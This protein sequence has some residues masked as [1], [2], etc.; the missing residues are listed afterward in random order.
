MSLSH[1]KPAL[2]VLF[3]SMANIVS[4]QFCS[5]SNV[6]AEV[7]ECNDNGAFYVDLE[8][9]VSSPAADRFLI[10]GNG[11]IYDTF[12]YGQTFYTVGPLSADCRTLYEFVI[13]DLELDSCFGVFEFSEPVCCA[14]ECSFELVDIERSD[15]DST[16]YITISYD[17][18]NENGSDNG[19]LITV[20]GVVLESNAYGNGP[21]ELRI[22]GSPLVNTLIFQDADQPECND[23]YSLPF[24]EYCDLELDCP[25][26]IVSPFIEF[27]CVSDSSYE[28]YALI[29]YGGDEDSLWISFYEA[30]NTPPDY[31]SL[32]YVERVAVQNAP[33]YLGTFDVSNTLYYYFISEQNNPFCYTA[34]EWNDAPDCSN[35]GSCE[36]FDFQAESVECNNLNE[37]LLQFSFEIENQGNEGFVLVNNGIIVDSFSYD[38]GTSNLLSGIIPGGC[39]SFSNFYIQD[40]ELGCQSEE[41]LIDNACCNGD[42]EIDSITVYDFECNNDGS[43]NL[44]LDFEYINN[45]NELFDVYAGTIYIGTYRYDELPVRVSNFIPRDIEYDLIRVCDNDNPDCCRAHEFIGPDCFEQTSCR[46]SEVFAE[47]YEC[48]DNSFYVDIEFDIV[49]PGNEGFIIRGNGVVYDSFSYGERFYTVGPIELDCNRAYEFIIIDLKK[50]CRGVFEM[51]SV[52]CCSE[53]C[54]I[55]DIEVFDFECNEDGSYD[56]TLDFIY[57]NN[58]NDFFDVYAGNTLI[59]FFSY[60]DLPVRVENFL[61]RNVEFDLIRICDNDN[62]DCCAIAEFRGPECDGQGCEIE[63]LDVLDIQY[64]ASGNVLFLL[65]YFFESDNATGLDIFINGQFQYYERNIEM[66]LEIVAEGLSLPDSVLIEICVNDRPDCCDELLLYLDGDTAGPC[67]L[68]A[69]QVLQTECD[70]DFYYLVVDAEHGFDNMAHN[71][72]LRGNGNEYGSYALSDLPVA[73]GPFHIEENINELGMV[74]TGLDEECRDAVELD[75]DCDCLSNIIEIDYSEFNITESSESIIIESLDAASFSISLF[76]LDGRTMLSSQAYGSYTLI[77]KNYSSGIYVLRI[78]H[79]GQERSFKI[80]IAN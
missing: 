22:P 56:L 48:T 73:I 28:A 9:D 14:E 24:N 45:T 12:E 36:I 26:A 17:V 33:Y 49:N 66:P 39:N 75:I 63:I 16:G 38:Q 54:S 13:I 74:I 29:E 40:I 70:E 23:T 78:L 50:E 34:N 77:K 19:F 37:Y 2:F 35:N 67:E 64:T 65:E 58:T 3:I 18:M 11:T 7:S 59:G 1:L 21:Y 68:F 20:N 42:C 25:L 60:A 5:I 41:V 55:R 15:C 53:D 8:F 51:P 47:A 6:F 57:E 69:M 46:I 27:E 32:I 76:A 62:P 72:T 80:F 71:F 43:Y 44:T 10:R 79:N 52:D 4:A 31:S 30:N 61:P